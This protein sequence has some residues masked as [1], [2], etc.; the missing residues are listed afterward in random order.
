MK[1]IYAFIISL[2]CLAGAAHSTEPQRLY[3]G[4]LIEC[5]AN[6]DAEI[7]DFEAPG[8]RKV[9]PGDA[10]PQGR[11]IWLKGYVRTPAGLLDSGKPAGIFVSAKASS[12]VYLNGVY[13]GANGAPGANRS[14]EKP[15]RMDAVFFAP[16]KHLTAEDNEILI[17]MSS[18]HGFLK[19]RS[20]VHTVAIGEYRDPTARILRAYWP[21]FIPFGVLIAGGLY[22][23][24][25]SISAANRFNLMLLSGVSFA[26][27]AQLGTEVFRGLVPYLYPVQEWRLLLILFFSFVFGVALIAHVIT[28]FVDRRRMLYV[29][30]AAAVTITSTFLLPGLDAKSGLAVLTPSILGII[31]AFAAARNRKPQARVYAIMLLFFASGILIFYRSFLDILFFY[32]T[33]TLVLILFVLQAISFQKERELRATE[34]ARA[35][36]LQLALDRV[37]QNGAGEQIRIKSAGKIDIINVSDI[38]Y[39]KGAGDYVELFLKDGR[40]VLHNETLAQL[41][42]NLPR[43]FLRVHRSYLVNTELISSLKRDKSGAGQLLLTNDTTI[44]VSRRIMPKV[45]SALI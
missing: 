27:A 38:S 4:W 8:C 42:E 28:R 43:I 17:R 20:P 6:A 7:P 9:S 2:T 37:Q 33:A 11:E 22:F 25:S 18:H 19:F 41:E 3:I 13:L 26:A 12:E 10:D 16:E 40:K 21:S 32:E 36:Q 45:R 14:I 30:S 23:A 31:I 34:T 39:C 29:A 1:Y 44:P 15:G 24:A 5:D 35:K